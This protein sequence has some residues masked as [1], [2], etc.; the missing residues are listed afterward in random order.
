[1]STLK[2][3]YHFTHC[4]VSIPRLQPLTTMHCTNVMVHVSSPAGQTLHFSNNNTVTNKLQFFHHAHITGELRI[5]CSQIMKVNQWHSNT[6][7]DTNINNKQS[8]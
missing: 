6:N 7:T 2:H 3:L 1:M 5:F 4:Y 8:M